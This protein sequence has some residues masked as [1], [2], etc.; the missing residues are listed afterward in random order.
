MRVDA[1]KLI[2]LARYRL[3]KSQETCD[4]S[5]FRKSNNLIQFEDIKFFISLRGKG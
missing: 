3:K 1:S 2:F 4:R 5:V